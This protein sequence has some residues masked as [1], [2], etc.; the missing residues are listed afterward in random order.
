MRVDISFN[1]ALKKKKKNAAYFYATKL[2]ALRAPISVSMTVSGS[3]VK[4]LFS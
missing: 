3:M 2:Q 1:S 4:F